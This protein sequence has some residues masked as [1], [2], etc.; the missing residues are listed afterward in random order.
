M[1]LLDER[2]SFTKTEE[3]TQGYD[4]FGSGK[5]S[6]NGMELNSSDVD[7]MQVL[8]PNNF[9]PRYERYNGTFHLSFSFCDFSDTLIF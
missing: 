9:T 8:N 5:L 7:S 2:N 3:R 4:F 6:K 1:Y